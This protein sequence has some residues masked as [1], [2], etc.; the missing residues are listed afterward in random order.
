MFVRDRKRISPIKK[1]V[2]I[3][4]FLLLSQPSPILS[5]VKV[6]TVLGKYVFWVL[7]ENIPFWF[8]W[9]LKSLLFIVYSSVWMSVV[10]SNV[11]TTVHMLTKFAP[12]L[13]LLSNLCTVYWDGE[14]HKRVL[15]NG[16][17]FC[18]QIVRMYRNS[19]KL[20]FAIAMKLKIK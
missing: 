16:W 14:I 11:Q 17:W 2:F 15:L 7:V 4:P 1:V 5:M 19:R 12:N 3:S 9:N 8:T 6:P 18:V 20:T 13:N 10:R